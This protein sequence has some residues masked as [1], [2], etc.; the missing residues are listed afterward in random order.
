MPE[1][2]SLKNIEKELNTKATLEDKKAFLEGIIKTAKGKIVVKLKKL[3]EGVDHAIDEEEQFEKNTE[4]LEQRL[5][6]KK[7]DDVEVTEVPADTPIYA[8]KRE[9]RQQEP[10]T[11]AS[12]L[13]QELVAD[14]PP[15]EERFVFT[16]TEH[17][18]LFKRD[19]TYIQ[20]TSQGQV[21][22]T[23][24]HY[25]Q[26]EGLDPTRGMSSAQ[27]QMMIGKVTE[28]LGGT[29]NAY[30]IRTYLASLRHTGL[31]ADVSKY[32]ASTT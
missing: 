8:R 4:L 3:L 9:P 22:S 19:I 11:P 25:L 29:A 1:K 32:K 27:E 28:Y 17:K 10:A 7:D 26:R 23:L 24:V 2:I 18:E 20:S 12:G 16:G 6:V 5:A 15:V 30:Q 31:P 13:E 21:L 14:K